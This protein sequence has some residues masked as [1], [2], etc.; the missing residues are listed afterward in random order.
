MLGPT[1]YLA[2]ELRL[3]GICVF[4]IGPGALVCKVEERVFG[5]KAEEYS[6]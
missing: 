6:D 2:R 3:C 4:A 1:K 5:P